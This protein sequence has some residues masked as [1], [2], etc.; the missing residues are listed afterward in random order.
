MECDGT[1]V[2]TRKYLVIFHSNQNPKG[3]H[4]LGVIRKSM[5]TKFEGTQTT[6]RFLDA[7]SAN[8]AIH[9]TPFCT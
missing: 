1:H 9:Q 3:H 4:H 6:H 2:I 5:G 8:N 7:Y